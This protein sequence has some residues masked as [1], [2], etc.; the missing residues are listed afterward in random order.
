M[1]TRNPAGVL[2]LVDEQAGIGGSPK[3]LVIN[4]LKIAFLKIVERD[5][6]RDKQIQ[7]QR[8]RP[9]RGAAPMRLKTS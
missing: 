8:S 4:I 1:P 3:Y 6:Q 2:E 7:T 5:G 9:S